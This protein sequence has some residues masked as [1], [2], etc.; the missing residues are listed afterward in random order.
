MVAIIPDPPR[1]ASAE[2]SGAPPSTPSFSPKLSRAPP[3][4][5]IF[6]RGASW[7]EAA[8]GWGPPSAAIPPMRQLHARAYLSR[9]IVLVWLCRDP[10]HAR[11]GLAIFT[12]SNLMLHRLRD[13]NSTQNE[14]NEL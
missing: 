14:L 7:G 4:A 3:R 1:R 13:S 12:R 10:S 2:P 8:P 11:P 6:G 5:S 9:R